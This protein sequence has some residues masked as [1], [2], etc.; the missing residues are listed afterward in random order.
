MFLGINIRSIRQLCVYTFRSCY[1]LCIFELRPAIYFNLLHF[2]SLAAMQ[3][4]V[5]NGEVAFCAHSP[6]AGGALSGKYV[7][8]KEVS[9]KHR[10]VQF[11]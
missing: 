2:T 6:L 5:S 9:R 7:N 8:P 4:A 3:E 10:L 11:K 1:I